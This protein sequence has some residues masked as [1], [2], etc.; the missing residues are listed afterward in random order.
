MITT[1]QLRKIY[2]EKLTETNSHDEAFTKAVW[3]AFEAGIAV[4]GGEV[5]EKF[6]KA[7]LNEKNK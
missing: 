5:T 7:F 1:S 2:A 6:R 3:V 4:C